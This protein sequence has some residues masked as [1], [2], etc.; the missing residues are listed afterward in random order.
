MSNLPSSA[1]APLLH[2]EKGIA[3]ITFNR[4]A[5]RN[6]LENEDLQTLLSHFHQANSDY[7]IYHDTHRSITCKL[8][9]RHFIS[10]VTRR[11]ITSL[12]D[13]LPLHES[14]LRATALLH[15]S[16]ISLLR[17]ALVR[18]FKHMRARCSL[19]SL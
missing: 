7:L 13:A 15:P 6:R 14:N 4:P 1:S 12:G 3:T 16:P 18:V 17:L 9:T 5:Q 10:L 8:L 11:V 2:I 19:A